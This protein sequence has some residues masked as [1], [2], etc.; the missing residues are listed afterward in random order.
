VEAVLAALRFGHLEEQQV[1]GVLRQVG[2]FHVVLTDL[3]HRHPEQG[4]PEAAQ[5]MRVLAVDGD[6]GDL[7]A[8]EASRHHLKIVSR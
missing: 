1:G 2:Q 4:A 6:G 3:D 7:H 8:A 5:L